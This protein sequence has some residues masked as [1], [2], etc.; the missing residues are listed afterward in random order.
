MLSHDEDALG[1][2]RIV[3]KL[4]SYLTEPTEKAL[5]LIESCASI[6]VICVPGLF[7]IRELSLELA[8]ERQDV[9]PVSGHGE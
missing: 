3:P 6:C 2:L 8:D 1:G 7:H 5:D 9:D 4:W